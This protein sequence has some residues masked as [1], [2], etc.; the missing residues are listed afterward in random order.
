NYDK[1]KR[2]LGMIYGAEQALIE[3]EKDSITKSECDAYTAGVNTYIDNLKESELPIEYKLLNYAPEKWTNLKSALFLKYMSFELA[4]SEDDFEYTNAKTVFGLQDF[5][6]MYPYL[7]DSL[8]PIIP[9]GTLYPPPAIAVKPPANADSLY[10]G[11]VDSLGGGHA[12]PDKDNGSNNWAVSGRKTKSGS[13]ILCNDPH[14]GLNLPSLWYEMQITTTEFNAYGVSFPGSPGVIIGF[15]DSCAFGFTNAMRDVRDYYEIQFKDESMKEYWFNG[16]WKTT[17]F[18][19]EK[20]GIKGEPNLIDTVAYTIFG[21]VMYDK[22]FTGSRRTNGNYY[23]VRWKAH[24]P[25]NELMLFNRLDHAKN[26]DD[27][28]SAIQYLHTPGQNCVFATKGGDIAIWDQGEF[29]AKWRRQGD[30]IMP[31]TD[32]SYMWQGTIPQPENPHLINPERG[33]VS[34]ANQF[35]VDPMYY[36]YYLGGSYPPYRGWLINKFLSQWTNITPKDMMTLQ[37]ENENAFAEMAKP[38]ILR[39]IDLTTLSEEEK[40]YYDILEAWDL[41]NDPESKGATLF[42]ILWENFTKIVWDDDLGRT[43]LPTVYPHASTLLEAILRDSSFKFLDN[44]NTQEKET[45]HDD[46]TV[47]FKKAVSRCKALDAD[48]RLLWAKY[49]ATR[50]NH[51]ARLT[52]FGR[53]DLPIGG[54]SNCINAAKEDHGPSWRMIVQLGPVTEA[55]G[56]YPGGQSGNPGS[57]YY[58]S[59]VDTWVAGKYYL[60]WV[61]NKD[62]IKDQR[63]KWVMNFSK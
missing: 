6:K 59:F 8:D 45:L 29:P 18:R 9:K 24:D 51:L 62:E 1:E 60:L 21:P 58:D 3:M 35:P 31:G 36:P 25:S 26:Y 47:A 46:M 30:F 44:V 7:Q 4:G 40:N 42:D 63:V 48:N 43:K 22:K 15:N 50:I 16:A 54:G 10:Y 32:S 57:P 33:Y 56:V 28:Y 13:P 23:A 34:S 19:Y 52:P 5:E 14:L 53:M 49:K 61:M 38:V 27:Y 17:T 39:N 20:I 2:R 37:T 55:Y 41:R 11:R 12:R